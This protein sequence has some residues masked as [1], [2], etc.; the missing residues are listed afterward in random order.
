MSYL[1]GTIELFEMY[2][3]ANLIVMFIIALIRFS[4]F[5]LFT[6][7][8]FVA[9]GFNPGLV[10]IP[11]II[12]AIAASQI[13]AFIPVT[14][15]GLGFREATFTGIMFTGVMNLTVPIYLSIGAVTLSLILNYGLGI[16][17]LIFWNLKKS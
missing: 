15:N 14:L 17:I 6:Y 12:L 2:S 8:S 4:S 16:L 7:F 1:E 13:I 11:L 10:L 9:F 5:V 3:V